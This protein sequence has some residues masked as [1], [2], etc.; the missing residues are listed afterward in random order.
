VSHVSHAEEELPLDSEADLEPEPPPVDPE[1]LARRSAALA[2]IRAYGDPV[3]TTRTRTVERFDAAL[4]DEA[5]HMASIMHE[6]MGIGLAAPQVGVL[7]RL[8][9]YRVEPDTPVTVLVN[10][11]LEWHGNEEEILEEGCLSLP[12]VHVDV[13][14]PIHVRVNA[15]DENGAELVI[16]ATGLEARVI[17]HEM[18]HL[19]GV[20]ILERTSR[21]QRKEAMRAMRE[22]QRDA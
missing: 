18:D 16:E 8:L 12:G 1:R 3:L 9:V 11:K 10:P 19:D 20:L 2:R 15:Q 14:R 17:Q 21:D 6:A 7:H 4:R 5:Q 22:A 13:E